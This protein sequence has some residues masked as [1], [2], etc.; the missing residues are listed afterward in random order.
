M[1]RR[2]FIQLC[3]GAFF[4]NRTSAMAA[5]SPLVLVASAASPLTAIP[6][7]DVRKAFLGVPVLV[8]DKALVPLVNSSSAD[9]KELFLQ[10]VLFMSSA[11]FERHCLSRIFK[12]GGNKIGDFS[13]ATSLTNALNAN[14]HSISYMQLGDARKFTSLRILGEL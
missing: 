8:N 14:P 7:N 1:T 2:A 9:S 12:N 4:F 5:E 3:V 11:V 13:D 10:R 6:A